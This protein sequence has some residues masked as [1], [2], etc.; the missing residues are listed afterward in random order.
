VT[1]TLV[2]TLIPEDVRDVCARLRGRGHQAF[3]V[4]GAVRD[5]L[6]GRETADYDVATDARPETVLQLFGHRFAIPTGLQ[7]GTVTVVTAARRNVEVT[8]YRGEGVYSDGRR[9]DQ[10]FFVQTIEEDLSRRD[11]T[12]NALAFDPAE[13]ALRDPEGGLADLAVRRIRAVGDPLTRFRE[14]GLRPMRAVRLAAQLEFT[15]AEGTLRSIPPA[16][17]VF[18]KVS[19]ERIRDELWKLLASPR[20]SIGLRLMHETGLLAEVLPE[21]CEGDGF[22]QNRHHKFDVLEHTLRTVDETPSRDPVVRFGALLHDV[23]KPRT[24]APREDAPAERTFY[25]HETVGADLADAISRRLKLSSRERERASLLVGQHMFYYR[26][27]WTDGTV[28]RFL[29]RVGPENVAD[30]FA[31]RAGDVRARGFGEDPETE[32][33]ELRRRIAEALER[34]AAL[35]IGDLAIGGQEVMEALRCVPGPRVGDVLRALLERVTDA[36][37]LNTRESLL[38]LLP[39]IQAELDRGGG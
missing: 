22:S 8:T 35:K 15:V 16:L 3:L 14:D 11:F 9:P 10:V 26:P 18:R 34:Q 21:L 32:I 6:L 27:E 12:I 37:A 2:R 31:L 4:G 19:A 20:P 13:E 28:L 29:R 30:L 38:G 7:H 1:Q 39:E 17:D 33:A 24:A 25:R 36:P 23:A 5:L